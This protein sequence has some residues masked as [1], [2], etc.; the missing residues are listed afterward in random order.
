MFTTH[1]DRIRQAEQKKVERLIKVVVVFITI[2]ALAVAVTVLIANLNMTMA[3]RVTQLNATTITAV[4][5]ANLIKYGSFKPHLVVKTLT[6][7]KTCS[8]R[9][10][11][12]GCFTSQS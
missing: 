10:S 5:T 12:A 2:V 3:K 8:H 11:K 1:K 4:T 9:F 7:V 6:V